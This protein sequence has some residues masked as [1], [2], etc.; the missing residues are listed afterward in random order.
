[1]L[2][3]KSVNRQ[4]YQ[5]ALTKQKINR[6]HTQRLT[7]KG[8]TVA[9]II[10]KINPR[11]PEFIENAAHMQVQVDDLKDKARGNKTRRR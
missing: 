3:L 4:Q 5:Y 6:T 7:I 9:K 11:S 8:Y 10:S 2:K 1:M